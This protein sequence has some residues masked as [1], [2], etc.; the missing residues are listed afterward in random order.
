MGYAHRWKRPD[1]RDAGQLR[2]FATD[3]AAICREYE[4]N[5]LR[6]AGQVGR[7]SAIINDDLVNFNG[8]EDCAHTKREEQLVYPS[9]G[10]GGM[11][12]NG[13][14]DVTGTWCAGTFITTRRCPG[15]C[16]YES[17]TI[18]RKWEDAAYRVK[19]G[20]IAQSCKT[21]YRPYDIAV[22]AC[23]LMLR[24]RFG[25]VVQLGSSGGEEDWRDGQMLCLKALGL[26][27]SILLEWD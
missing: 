3:C 12:D 27:P 26:L 23:L 24:H 15:S 11:M 22:T 25:N 2:Q 21:N 5:D 1:E 4:A 19:D 6:L 18:P 9:S 20:R 10:A 14:P 16:A 17:L 8:A 7:G 13:E